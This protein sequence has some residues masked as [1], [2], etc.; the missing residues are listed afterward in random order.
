M[1]HVLVVEYRIAMMRMAS[2]CY[3]RCT[4]PSI[5]Q[6]V[7]VVIIVLL[8]VSLEAKGKMEDTLDP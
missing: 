4:K 5:D 7:S 3:S 6:P 8:F 1:R 2:R